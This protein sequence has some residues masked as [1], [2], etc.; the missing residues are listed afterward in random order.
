MAVATGSSPASALCSWP[1]M[2]TPARKGATI[3]V[4]KSS[5]FLAIKASVGVVEIFLAAR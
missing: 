4:V 5:A 3:I 1:S 2:V